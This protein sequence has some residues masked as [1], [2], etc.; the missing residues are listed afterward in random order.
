MA[1]WITRD[2]SIEKYGTEAYTG[3]NSVD[4]DADFKAKGGT[5]GAGADPINEFAS[6]FAQLT[7]SPVTVPEL[8][9]DSF[10]EYEERALEEL[11]PYYERILEEEGGDVERAK[12][13]IEQD[14]QRGMRISRED[15][16]VAK[17][18]QGP[19]VEPGETIQDYYNR[20]KSE[21]GSFPQ[22]GIKMLDNLMKRRVQH[23]GIAQTDTQ[24]LATAQKRRQEALDRAQGRYAE[25]IGINR[26]RTLGDIDRAW[27]RRQFELGE[28][29][30]EKAGRLGRQKRSDDIATQE[31]ERA[32]FMRKAINNIYG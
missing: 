27:S 6:T 26:E 17:E 8:Q 22:E 32:N 24:N 25:K 30:K 1:D 21:F 9:V 10:E 11:R 16:S 5:P 29:K 15:L 4:A 19:A 28:E 20:T 7:A 13:R 23:S 18:S 2:E 12:Q 31:I 14:Y 3:W